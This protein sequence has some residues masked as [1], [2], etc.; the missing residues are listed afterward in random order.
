MFAILQFKTKYYALQS[1]ALWIS[2]NYFYLMGIYLLQTG[3]GNK[4]LQRRKAEHLELRRQLRY[5][6]K[7]IKFS[8]QVSINLTP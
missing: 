5:K 6:Q 3:K 8:K 2:G 4:K 1:T 7:T